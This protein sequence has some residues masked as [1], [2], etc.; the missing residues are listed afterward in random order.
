MLCVL[1]RTKESIG[2]ATRLAIDCA[3][4]GIA[5]EVV[6][7]LLRNLE[8]ESSLNRKID[9][10]FLVDSI[11][12]CSRG[13]KGDPDAYP[14]LV[15]AVLPRFLSAAA[16]PGHAA[17][18]NRRQ[19]MKV[20]RLWLE[21]KTLPESV[22]RH[23]MRELDS[24]GGDAS[25]TG[26]FSRRPLRTE[27]A[28]ND[29]VR[30][31]EGILVDEYGSNTSFSLPGFL[32]PRI[33]E[34][35]E[36]GNG[37]EGKCSFT[38]PE[39]CSEIADGRSSAPQF[40]S[41]KHKHIL[42]DVDG[43]LEMEDVSPSCDVETNSVCP[44]TRGDAVNPSGYHLD[45]LSPFVPPLPDDKPPS[46]PPLPSS[47]PPSV[48]PPP[49]VPSCPP[50]SSHALSLPTSDPTSH[51]ISDTVDQ[52]HH[53]VE[54]K[55][56]VQSTQPLD[57]SN[58]NS[59]S[60]GLPSHAPHYGGLPNQ[61]LTPVFSYS[62]STSYN[63]I[64]GPHPSIHSGNRDQPRQPL[65]LP[66]KAYHL[67]PPPPTVSNQFSYVQAEPREKIESWGEHSS[68]SLNGK[69]QFAHDRYGGDI[70]SDTSSFGPVRHE[71][72]DGYRFSAP[73]HSGSVNFDKHE[74]SCT[75]QSYSVPPSERGWSYPPRASTYLHSAHT[76]GRS[77]GNPFARVAG[78]PNYWRPR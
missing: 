58:A 42:E 31:M 65:P 28:M 9:L 36:E 24:L 14:S 48:P 30:E 29:P 2:R 57:S 15:Q 19:C 76:S 62:S 46:P 7:I 25:L 47:P 77:Q 55:S 71:S 13:Q 17:L 1:S 35:E 10:F 33:L 32:V 26:G 66:K 41:N 67:Q 49:L 37:T 23:H 60:D 8:E 64:P 21:R 50:L 27:R 16:P 72:V 22:V 51:L 11:T 43:E 18:E 4:Y 34:D 6:E 61:L 52:R 3:K 75:S 44:V 70:C 38:V 12:Q 53:D 63:S 40:I 69:L 54:H 56:L 74:S 68:P 78:A 39:K 5:G 20:L 45:R 59:S 73:V